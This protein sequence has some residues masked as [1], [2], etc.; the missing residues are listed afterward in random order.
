MRFNDAAELDRTLDWL[1]ENTDGKPYGVDVVMPM[2]VPTEGTS[3]DLQSMI[4]A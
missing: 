2:T 1:D 4:P 3:V